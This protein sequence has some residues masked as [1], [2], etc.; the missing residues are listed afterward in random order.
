MIIVKNSQLN[1]ETIDA[2]N[3]LMVLDINATAAFR[4]SRIIKDLS[5][6]VDDKI[7]AEK[8]ILDRYVAKDEMG[9]PIIPVDELGQKIEGSL[10]IDDIDSFT[11]EMSELMSLEIKLNHDKLNFDS[12]NLS[13]NVKIKD[14]IKLEFLFE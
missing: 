9:N 8:R 13:S 2:L 4:L 11:K 10:S 12:L 1:K 6:I 14:I 3:Q 7:L 5:S